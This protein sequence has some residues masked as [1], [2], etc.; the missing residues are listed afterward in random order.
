MVGDDVLVRDLGMA[1]IVADPA[2]EI[3]RSAHKEPVVVDRIG[4]IGRQE[5]VAVHPV[6]PA[7]VPSE[8]LE[9]L[10]FVPQFADHFFHS[11]FHGAYSL[12]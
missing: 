2:P 7:G 10:L 5:Q 9:D 3:L 11:G 12:S 1:M 6:N 8:G 4:M